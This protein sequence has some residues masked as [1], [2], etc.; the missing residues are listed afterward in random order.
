MN[1]VEYYWI[2]ICIHWRLQSFNIFL[3][4]ET[5][6]D[7]R[8]RWLF[9]YFLIHFL[10]AM[11]AVAIRNSNQSTRRS[12]VAS[13]H[14]PLT[15]SNPELPT[16]I[17]PADFVSIDPIGNY[18]RYITVMPFPMGIIAHDYHR[19]QLS[20]FIIRFHLNSVG[21]NILETTSNRWNNSDF[22]R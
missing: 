8:R 19:S 15:S 7:E 6:T 16:G 20:I 5:V 9:I 18:L 1:I 3:I 10:I 12:R 17:Y 13:Q 14:R 22:H 4:N 21:I 11:A 2:V